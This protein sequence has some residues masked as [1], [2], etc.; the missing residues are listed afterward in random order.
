M[1]SSL[2]INEECVASRH[3]HLGCARRGSPASAGSSDIPTLDRVQQVPQYS[4]SL[5]QYG[6]HIRGDRP[7]VDPEVSG[8]L[9]VGAEAR[10]PGD[11][12]EYP[13]TAIVRR[14]SGRSGKTLDSQGEDSY[15]HA[16]SRS[17]HTRRAGK[18]FVLEL[19][20]SAAPS[21][22]GLLGSF[23]RRTWRISAEGTLQC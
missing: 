9:V 23:T 16:T 7:G 1:A 6:I 18:L 2:R 4:A 3:R 5:R 12:S 21:C 8:V 22:F 10:L 15:K 11:R 17:L 20:L 13:G 19:H 14:L